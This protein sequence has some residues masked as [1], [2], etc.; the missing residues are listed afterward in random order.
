[1]RC[2]TRE[3]RFLT[4]RIFCYLLKH[5]RGNSRRRLRSSIAG[6]PCIARIA[7]LICNNR[8]VSNVFLASRMARR[9]LQAFACKQFDFIHQKICNVQK[10]TSPNLFD[11]YTWINPLICDRWINSFF[12]LNSRVFCC[13]FLKHNCGNSRR[14]LP[15][16]LSEYSPV[17][18]TST[19]H[20]FKETV[21]QCTV[22]RQ[23]WFRRSYTT[24]FHK[25][26]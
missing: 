15:S 25:L 24:A 19:D 21:F 6:F 4:S 5:N 26:L 11:A 10:T 3:K 23:I 16:K 20:I 17:F 7:P 9:L 22:L 18:C 13:Y 8:G 14:R 12:L 2:S 1:M